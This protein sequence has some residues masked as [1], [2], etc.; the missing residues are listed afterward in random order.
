[1]SV[2]EGEFEWKQIGINPKDIQLIEVLESIESKIC[3]HFGVPSILLDIKDPKFNS[4]SEA[5]NHFNENVINGYI[6]NLCKKLT[7]FFNKEFK[8]IKDL[9]I[10]N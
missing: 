3:N 8:I 7:M 2:L 1:M 4:Y 10:S 6:N 5:T 9:N